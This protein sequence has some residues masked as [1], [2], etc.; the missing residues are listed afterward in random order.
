MPLLYLEDSSQEMRLSMSL[1]EYATLVYHD[2]FDHPLTLQELFKWRIS[3]DYVETLLKGKEFSVVEVF[4]DKGYIYLNKGKKLHVIRKLRQKSIKKGL[5]KAKKAAHLLSFVPSV[6]MVAVLNSVGIIDA[7]KV[8]LIVTTK[9]GS[10]WTTRAFSLIILE[11]FNFFTKRR[12]SDSSQQLSVKVWLEEDNLTWKRKD[13]IAAHE[14]VQITPL[15][16]K[17]HSYEKLISKNKW[18][19]KFFPNALAERVFV[20]KEPKKG[21]SSEL[22]NSFF[23]AFNKI[24]YHI[25]YAFLRNMKNKKVSLKQAFFNSSDF[26]SIVLKRFQNSLIG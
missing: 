3:E 17:N 21:Y 7:D 16:D 11:L 1:G 19:Q 25:Q 12:N 6:E 15:V 14:F 13:L 4:T 26:S 18:Y 24:S 2:M 10:L 20:E 22:V 8:D 9:K 5:K 23:K